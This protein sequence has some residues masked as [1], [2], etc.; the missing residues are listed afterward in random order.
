MADDSGALLGELG[1]LTGSIGGYTF[2]SGALVGT[3]GGLTGE[4]DGTPSDRTGGG[5]GSV[6]GVTGVMTATARPSL[7]LY[8]SDGLTKMHSLPTAINLQ[9][10]DCI[11]RPGSV[12]FDIPAADAADLTTNRIV[13][14]FWKGAARIAARLSDWDAE[15]AV[16]DTAYRSYQSVPGAL[17]MWKDAIVLPEYPLSRRDT[18]ETRTFGAMSNPDLPNSVGGFFIR[19]DWHTPVGAPWKTAP[20][21]KHRKPAGLSGPNPWWIAKNSPFTNAANDEL[22]WFHKAFTTYKGFPYTIYATADNYLTLYLDGEQIITPDQQNGQTWR[23]LVSFKGIMQPGK[24]LLAAKVENATLNNG[25]NPVG[26]ILALVQNDSKGDPVKGAPVVKT[27][28]SWLV[29]DANAGWRRALPIIAVHTEAV[30]REVL[31]ATQLGLNWGPYH[32]SSG[33]AWTEKGEW[34]ANI[35]DKLDD[36]AMAQAE[37]VFDLHVNADRMICG[38]FQRYGIDR[39]ATVELQLGKND[40]SLL[41]DNPS[42][43]KSRYTS[44]YLHLAD[45]TWLHKTQADE[46]AG[47]NIVEVVVSLGGTADTDTAGEVIDQAFAVNAHSIAAL[48]L[49]VSTVTG[50]Q[51]YTHFFPGDTVSIPDTAGVDLI[52]GRGLTFTVDASA[53][54]I[55]AWVGLVQDDSV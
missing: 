26:L 49:E 39:S 21:V 43:V 45:G 17:A 31:G 37:K 25:H 55:R 44:A 50:P 27:D 54:V 14:V 20:G 52:K 33:V 11:S 24:H 28:T 48:T 51:I 23:G 9:W 29:T 30:A 2:K 15:Y 12:S 38:A 46:V 40:G 19:A 47:G 4:I 13:K 3:L 35:G 34:T 10:Q 41:S 22:Q 8:H 1:G 32:D 53:P 16:H 7:V 6:G 5:G 42:I 18:G 36:F